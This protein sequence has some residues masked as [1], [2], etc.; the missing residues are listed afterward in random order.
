MIITC[1]N[2]IQLVKEPVI[3]TST[4]NGAT[5]EP[6]LRLATNGTI[7]EIAE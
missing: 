6:M 2:V 1:R 7:R 5:F 3:R 4:D